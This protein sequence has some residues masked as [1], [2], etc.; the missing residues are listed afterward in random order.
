MTLLEDPSVLVALLKEGRRLADGGE[1]RVSLT[2][3]AGPGS[4]GR[5]VAAAVSVRVDR[6]VGIGRSERSPRLSEG[7]TSEAVHRDRPFL[8]SCLCPTRSEQSLVA[9]QLLLTGPRLAC[10]T[11]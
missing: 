5:S 4:K 9:H 10:Y 11:S 7:W 8:M 2:G 1:L 3:W 6:I